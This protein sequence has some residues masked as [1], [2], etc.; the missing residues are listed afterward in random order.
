MMSNWLQLTKEQRLDTIYEVSRQ[1]SGIL[2]IQAIEKDWWVTLAL[3]AVFQT[4]YAK[5]LLFK[6]G[7]SLSK[8]WNLIDRFSEDIDLAIDRDILGYTGNPTN[9]QIK[10]LKKKACE[11][12]SNELRDA[13][14]AQLLQSGIPATAFKLTAA[15][16]IDTD[17]DPQQ[18]ILAY[19]SLLDPVDYIKS[20]IQIEISGR[21]LKEPWSNRLVQSFIDTGYSGQP[22]TG[23]PF[24]VPTVEPRRTFLEKAFLLHEEFSKPTEKIRSGRMSRHLYDLDVLMDTEHG[25]G[26][27]ADP[28]LYYSIIEHRAIFNRLPG[29]DYNTHA[30]TSI[31]F[32]PPPSVIADWEADYKTMRET[33]FYGET[34]SFA[35]LIIRLQV[36]LERFR[37]ITPRAEKF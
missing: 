21:S 5:Y 29:I 9:S 10:K 33:M 27:L 1:S 11:F 30:P 23:E 14:E 2:P 25:T 35:D 16:V 6:G 12:I 36:L 18:L 26:A 34:K 3:K 20:E 31:Y 4:P 13:I 7:T 32:I 28:E 15:E 17:K 24:E 37:A 8:S 19:D 22:F